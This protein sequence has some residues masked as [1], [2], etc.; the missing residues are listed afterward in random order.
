MVNMNTAS[1]DSSEEDTALMRKGWIVIYRDEHGE[2]RILNARVYNNQRCAFLAYSRAM[3]DWE[4]VAS[5]CIKTMSR[6]ATYTVR[7]VY[8]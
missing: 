8:W 1:S 3:S 2:E 4:R 7:P 5:E 6:G